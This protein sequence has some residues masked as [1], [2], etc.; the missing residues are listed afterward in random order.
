M[1]GS[2]LA[3]LAAARILREHHDVTVYERGGTDTAT[4][5]QGICL[6]SNGVK[7]LQT[8]GF[9]RARVGAVP[10]YGYRALDKNGNQLQ[11]FPVDFK[12][13]YGADTLAMK[14]SDFRDELLL[15][16]TAPSEDLGIQGHPAQVIF[17]TNVVDIDP[18]E[19]SITLED[20]SVVGADV[21]IIADGVHSRLRH[22]IVGSDDARAK[23]NGMTCYRVAVSAEAVNH[24][25]GYL[26]AWWDPQTADGRISAFQAG[27]GSNRLIAAYAIRNAEYM[28]LAC[29]FP[30][31][32]NRGN[33]LESWY[34]DGNRREMIETFDDYCEPMRKILGIA[35]EVK[36]WELQDID[37]LPNWNRGRTILI[38]DA[39]HA[40]TPMQGQG[41]NMALEDADALR[42][43]RPGM[44]RKDISAVLEQVDG[45][46]RPRATRVLRDTRVQA[47]DITLEERIANLDYNCGYNGVFEALKAMK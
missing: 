38:G 34:A 13:K 39:A 45:V 19:A 10:C 9:D 8:M 22:R 31:R 41:A 30:T 1:F 15:L 43:L 40:M 17:N 14:R 16:A 7:I 23:K 3:G 27:D 2:G 46:R 25:L 11:D 5:G 21:V 44:S 35:T 26:P 12:A 37:P 28:N 20:G 6:F 29:V 42:L 18:E 24:T 32:Q 47:K 33:V 36:V 4:G